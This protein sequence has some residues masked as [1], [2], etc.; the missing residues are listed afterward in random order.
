MPKNVEEYTDLPVD[1]IFEILKNKIESRKEFAVLFRDSHS[2]LSIYID[3]YHTKNRYELHVAKFVDLFYAG[4]KH[5]YIYV[6][7]NAIV[8][9]GHLHTPRLGSLTSIGANGMTIR[10]FRLHKTLY[11]T[12]GSW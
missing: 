7:D 4:G 9:I 1:K 3:Y 5:G 10:V 12:S 8:G 6:P 11:F 2:E